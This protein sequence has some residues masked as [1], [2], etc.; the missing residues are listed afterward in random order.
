[1]AARRAPPERPDP[2]AKQDRAK[3]RLRDNV[4][5]NL[6]RI[7]A[8]LSLSQRQLSE[9]AGVS[10]T[11]ISQAEQSKR[12]LSLDLIAVLALALGKTPVDLVS[13]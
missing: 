13:D 1:M 8:E 3:A 12:N 4:A 2:E 9:R 11:Y 7:R 10:Q 5:R 6:L